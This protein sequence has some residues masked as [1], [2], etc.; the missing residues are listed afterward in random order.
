VSLYFPGS[1]PRFSGDMDIWIAVNEVNAE[2]V[3]AA[4]RDFGMPKEALSKE[5]FLEKNKIIR[6]GVPPVRIEV[7]T[8]ASGVEFEACY[9]HR[10]VA[11]MDDL[12]IN[13]ISLSDLKL[14]KLS[15]GRHKDL[16]DIEH[17]P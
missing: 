16:E 12:V 2:K 1:V 11:K 13:I 14:N 9:E 17:I 5:M 15:A 6:M 4:V 3:V 10:N 8:G 7:I